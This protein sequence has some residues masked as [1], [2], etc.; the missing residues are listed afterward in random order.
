MRC[1]DNLLL[2]EGL[3]NSLSGSRKLPLNLLVLK[4]FLFIRDENKNMVTRG[5]F[6]IIFEELNVIWQRAYLPMKAENKCLG[7]L[8]FLH[9]KWSIL[10]KIELSRGEKPATLSRIEKFKENM[11]QLCDFSPQ[12]VVNQK[13]AKTGKKIIVFS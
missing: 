7:Q 1:T 3:S 4:R 10:R 2:C 9:K 13:D 12:D 8:M 11:N 5:T 6:K